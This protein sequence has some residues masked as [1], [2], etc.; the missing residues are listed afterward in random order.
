MDDGKW[1][2][3]PDAKQAHQWLGKGTRENIGRC[4]RENEKRHVNKKA[5]KVN[6]EH[7]YMGVRF[8][9]ESYSEWIKKI[10]Q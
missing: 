1:L 2:F 4:C 7:R 5:G 6:T 3:L 8:Y 10:K 9:F